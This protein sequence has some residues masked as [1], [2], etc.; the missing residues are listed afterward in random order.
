MTKSYMTFQYS[1]EETI[2]ELQAQVTSLAEERDKLKGKVTDLEAGLQIS[3]DTWSDQEDEMD[4]LKSL[5]SKAEEE[6]KELLS[7]LKKISELEHQAAEPF[8]ICDADYNYVAD[9]DRIIVDA[10]NIAL[11]SLN[12]SKGEEE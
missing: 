12:K 1:L 9:Q 6:N 10:K 3:G 5:L 11:A 7:A 8:S 4:G 2:E